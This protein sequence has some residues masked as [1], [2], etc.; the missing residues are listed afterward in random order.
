MSLNKIGKWAFGLGVLVA[1]FA[2]FTSFGLSA[3]TIVQILF[4]LG[5]IVGFLNITSNNTT[6]FLIAVIALLT[7][8]IGS[9]QTIS[10]L[11]ASV[12]KYVTSMLGNFIAFVGA[13]GVIVAIKEIF[14][15]SDKPEFGPSKRKSRK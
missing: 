10:I 12:S 6:G 4:V 8:G 11:G 3:T 2:A 7:L 15:T 14:A 9:I 5:L 1:V 13:A